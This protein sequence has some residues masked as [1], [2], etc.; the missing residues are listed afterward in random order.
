ME[1]DHSSACLMLREYK[2]II[3][4]LTKQR[5]YSSKSEF[6]SLIDKMIQKT[7]VYL[8]EALQCNAVLLATMLNPA[9][10][11]SVFQL[12]FKSCHSYAK[13]LL[14]DQFNQ[15]KAEHAA[16]AVS[17]A[18]TPP[19]ISQPVPSNHIRNTDDVNLFPDASESPADDKLT[20]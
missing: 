14:Q 8:N 17:Q 16:K 15:C 20:T 4:F 11:L 12:W 10:Q 18:S 7:T 1:G 3:E 5:N 19:I 13:C 2:H 9:Y 6:H